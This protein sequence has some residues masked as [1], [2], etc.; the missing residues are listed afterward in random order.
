M[1]SDEDLLVRRHVPKG[2]HL[3]KV[4]ARGMP[5]RAFVELAR[6]IVVALVQVNNDATAERCPA[7]C[8]EGRRRVLSS[9][10][11]GLGCFAAGAVPVR[12]GFAAGVIAGSVTVLADVRRRRA[13]SAC[14]KPASVTRTPLA[15]GAIMPGDNLG[16]ERPIDA[17]K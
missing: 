3:T 2:E 5:P 15:A 9:W 1:D 8:G 13:G 16:T 11:K 17:K 10:S 4:K 6:V 14:A 7:L 12:T